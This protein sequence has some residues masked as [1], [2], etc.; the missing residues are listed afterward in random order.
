M[1][2]SLMPKFKSYR[3][4]KPLWKYEIKCCD[5][6]GKEYTKDNMMCT[7]EGKHVYNWYCIRCHN[8]RWP[9]SA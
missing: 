7:Q 6:C 5:D 8:F 2:K 4:F 1:T 9:K 3:K